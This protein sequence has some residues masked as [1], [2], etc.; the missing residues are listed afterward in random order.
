MVPP[1]FIHFAHLF[2]GPGPGSRRMGR[3]RASALRLSAPRGRL[4][5]GGYHAADD[6]RAADADRLPGSGQ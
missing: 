4:G 2:S 1:I 6:A 5:R 3:G